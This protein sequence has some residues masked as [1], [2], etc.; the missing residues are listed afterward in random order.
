MLSESLK[1][2]SD[3]AAAGEFIGLKYEKQRCVLNIEPSQ[4]VRSDAAASA[5]R[6]REPRQAHRRCALGYTEG[7]ASANQAADSCQIR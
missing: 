4:A 6:L 7:P 2:E 5:I 3:P 1:E